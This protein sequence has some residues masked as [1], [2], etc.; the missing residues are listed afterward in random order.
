MNTDF[1]QFTILHDRLH[2]DCEIV[3]LY[4]INHYSHHIDRMQYSD[5]IVGG[6]VVHPT[7]PPPPGLPLWD[8][9]LLVILQDWYHVYTEALL[10]EYFSV[11][12][13]IFNRFHALLINGTWQ[14]S[15]PL[16]T[17]AGNEPVPDSAVSWNLLALYAMNLMTM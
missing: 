4:F 10:V 9:D 12:F 16:G 1:G 14:P 6:I 5:G 8:E 3:S 11:S 17:G 2:T 13:I 15:G 7:A